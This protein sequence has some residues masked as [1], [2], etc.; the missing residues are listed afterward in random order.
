MSYMRY[1][2]VNPVN[3]EILN[4]GM[5]VEEDFEVQGLPYKGALVVELPMAEGASVRSWSHHFDVTGESLSDRQVAA[6][7]R[8]VAGQP[9]LVGNFVEGAAQVIETPP[10]GGGGKDGGITGPGASV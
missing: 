2:V 8:R 9:Q 10:L 1:A 7:P 4:T 3:G 5:C 6:G